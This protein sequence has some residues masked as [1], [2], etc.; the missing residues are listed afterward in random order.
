[1]QYDL[2]EIEYNCTCRKSDLFI[3][4]FRSALCVPI[5][6]GIPLCPLRLN[7]LKILIFLIFGSTQAFPL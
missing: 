1:M 7:F 2:N 5:A 3:Y 6:I 4:F